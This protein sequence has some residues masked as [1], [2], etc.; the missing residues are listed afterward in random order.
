MLIFFFWPKWFWHIHALVC[1]SYK[2]YF[3][4]IFYILQFL[5]ILFIIFLYELKQ[6]FYKLHWKTTI[7]DDCFFCIHLLLVKFIILEWK[8]V[9]WSKQIY[10]KLIQK[11]LRIFI[12][13]LFLKTHGK[14][15]KRITSNI[16]EHPNCIYWY[17]NINFLN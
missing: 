14:N 4:K 1:L 10:I 6:L 17:K 2:Q 12:Y 8:Y 3:E 15:S 9:W 13:L 16:T 11:Y 5:F 7:S